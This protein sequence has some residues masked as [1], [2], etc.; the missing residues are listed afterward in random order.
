MYQQESGKGRGRERR[1]RKSERERYTCEKRRASFRLMLK[2]QAVNSLQLQLGSP[3]FLQRRAR[4][5]LHFQL[6]ANLQTFWQG[7]RGDERGGGC[8]PFI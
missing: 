1:W 8:K 5:M 4:F 6:F 3:Q 7:G 2:I